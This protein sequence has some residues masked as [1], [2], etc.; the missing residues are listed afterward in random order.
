MYCIGTGT[1][2]MAAKPDNFLYATK[3]A[4]EA[5]LFSSSQRAGKALV[6]LPRRFYDISSNWSVRPFEEPEEVAIPVTSLVHNT[7]QQQEL[8]NTEDSGSNFDVSEF[9]N[10]LNTIADLKSKKNGCLT[11]LNSELSRINEEIIDIEHFIEFSKLNA[12]N[13][14]SAYKMLRDTL[15]ERRRIKDAITAATDIFNNCDVDKIAETRDIMNNR[16]YNP[17]QLH[18]LFK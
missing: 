16:H 5:R 1:Q 15:T 10:A 2:Y 8:A 18:G 7:T 13:A 17:R 3:N 4:D 9:V 6:K 14:Y 11:K 12:P